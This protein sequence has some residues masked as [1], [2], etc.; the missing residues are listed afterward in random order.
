MK[1]VETE[2][3]ELKRNLNEYFEKEVVSFLNTHDGIIYIGVE[4]DGTICGVDKVDEIMKKIADVVSTG[5]LP[6]PQELIKIKAILE[7]KQFVIQVK[8]KRGKSVYYIKKYGRSSKGCYIR[9][10]T[11]CRSMTEEQIEKAFTSSLETKDMIT[12][13]P[14]MYSP[15]SFRQL[16][17]YYE[18]A[19]LHL[20]EK[21][22]EKN[23]NLKNKEG[24]YNKLA[25]LLSDTNRVGLIYARFNG[26]DKSSY[27][28]TI[29]HGN[30]CLITSIERMKNRLE[31]ENFGMSKITF[32]KRIDKQLVDADCLREALYNAVAHNDWENSRIPI[33]YRFEILSYGGIP[34]GQTKE[35]FL[36]GISKPRSESLM[37][38]L[39]D[40]GYAERTGHGVLKIVNKYGSKSFTFGDDY[41]IVTLPFDKEVS[42]SFFLEDKGTKEEDKGTKK[43]EI[44]QLI[45][46]QISNMN[47][48]SIEELAYKNSVSKK[49]VRY[50]IDKLRDK[51]I[52]KR[53]GSNRGG[54]WIIIN[55]NENK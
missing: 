50:H 19:E 54:Y 17:N 10:G 7:N 26:K 44:D 46:K 47:K 11:S 51:G 37:R 33:I 52:I 9:V 32:Q 39:R 24:K 21:T 15:I 55:S 23:L 42:D 30:Q 20:N 29:D 18:S 43:E 1:Y 48:I 38:I 3:V 36:M 12:I 31:A 6:N 41:I 16:K 35:K 49:T 22:F 27:G 14:T 5:I 34:N 45:L 53:I 25:E 2:K 28:E 8:I 4:D 13:I 40:L